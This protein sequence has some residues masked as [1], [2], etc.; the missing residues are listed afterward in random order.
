[1]RV[2]KLNNNPSD[3]G[4]IHSFILF[5]EK[6]DYWITAFITNIF[7]LQHPNCPQKSNTNSE[8]HFGVMEQM[9]F[10]GYGH[11]CAWKRDSFKYINLS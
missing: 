4:Q 8:S 7:L 1:M 9:K 3:K 5:F 6:H 2:K 10:F 11:L